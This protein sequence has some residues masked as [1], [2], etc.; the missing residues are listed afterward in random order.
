MDRFAWLLGLRGVWQHGRRNLIA[1]IAIAIGLIAILS[2]IGYSKRINDYQSVQAMYLQQPG[3]VAIVKKDGLRKRLTD[4]R[5]YSLRAHE[6]TRI[7]RALEKKANFAFVSPYLTGFGLI[8]SGG[9]SFPFKALA[10]PPETDQRIKNHPELKA[11]ISDY[12][13]F[14]RGVAPLVS[15]VA[16]PIGITVGLAKRLGLKVGSGDM[17]VQ[18]LTQDLDGRLN[19]VDGDLVNEYS[20][21][22]SFTDNSGVTMGLDLLQE[23]LRTDRVSYLGVFLKDREDAKEFAQAIK[24]EMIQQ[25]LD[26]DAFA[27]D[28][29]LWNFNFYAGRNILVVMS[30]FA[31]VVIFIVVILSIVN[32]LN[33]GLVEARREIGML[34]ALGFTPSQIAKIFAIE[35]KAVA[36]IA[37]ILGSLGA[38]GLFRAIEAMQI[39][40]QFPGASQLTVVL[41][42]PPTWAYFTAALGLVILVVLTNF[43]IAKRYASRDTLTLLDRG[44]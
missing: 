34:R 28:D 5:R 24:V 25:K 19:A 36:W 4:P 18:L 26:I 9:K 21:G 42:T 8:G 38:L 7:T 3:H 10:M 44:T 12:V 37:V 11:I 30:I 13:P 27:W 33:I 14:T 1:G 35:A 16:S 39:P 43:L 22:V 40:F 15:G 17:N 20:T 31:A 41:V 23:L 6:V 32:T 29:K 2:L